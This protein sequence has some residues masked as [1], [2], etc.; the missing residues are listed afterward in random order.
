MA[1]T[2]NYN[3]F[4]MIRRPNVFKLKKKNNH[5]KISSIFEQNIN[6]E[7]FIFSFITHL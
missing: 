2:Q 7:E 1:N 3:V 4:F 6:F 5:I